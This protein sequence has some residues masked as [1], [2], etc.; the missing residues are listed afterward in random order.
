MRSSDGLR[1][2]H[3][4]IGPGVGGLATIVDAWIAFL[5]NP[6]AAIPRTRMPPWDGIIKEDEYPAL[7]TY[8]RK[9]A[10]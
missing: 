6:T 4:T 7:V 5:K 2:P 10:R 3:M 1:S 8:V 9:L